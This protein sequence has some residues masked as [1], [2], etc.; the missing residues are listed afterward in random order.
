MKW[1]PLLAA[2]GTLTVFAPQAGAVTLTNQDGQSYLMEIVLGEGSATVEELNI[3]SGE[4]ITDLCSDGCAIR[5]DNGEELEFS[6]P[7]IAEIIDGKF[8]L[9]E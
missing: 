6:G 8:V 9:I 5:L 3:E 1:I 4:S 2:L 7:E